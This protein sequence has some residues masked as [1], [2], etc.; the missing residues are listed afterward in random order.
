MTAPPRTPFG[1][2]LAAVRNRFGQ[3]PTIGAGA[4]AKAVAEDASAL[5]RAEIE[6]AKAEL[7]AS[8]KPKAT[9]AGLLVGAGVFGWLAL[10]GLLITAALVLALVLPAWAAALIV[11]GVLLLLGGGLALAGKR[12][13]ATPVSLDITKHNVEEDV[14]WTKSHLARQ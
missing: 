4:A 1:Q 9:G 6:L 3:Q 5:V 13:L 11:S 10:Q 7:A 2:P 12:K 8:V 14:A